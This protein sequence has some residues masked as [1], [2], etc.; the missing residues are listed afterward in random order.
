MNLAGALDFIGFSCLIQPDKFCF[1]HFA[2]FSRFSQIRYKAQKCLT[3]GETF[4]Y[5]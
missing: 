4:F 5:L 2:V 1:S 3:S